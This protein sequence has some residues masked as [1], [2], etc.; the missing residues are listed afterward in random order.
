MDAGKHIRGGVFVRAKR[1]S[2]KKTLIDG[3]NPAT[4]KTHRGSQ[5]L[6]AAACLSSSAGKVNQHGVYSLQL[7]APPSHF[8]QTLFAGAAWGGG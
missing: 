7:L 6:R 4:R 5:R 8:A 1:N 3:E 2:R